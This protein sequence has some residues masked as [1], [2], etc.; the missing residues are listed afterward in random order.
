MVQLSRLRFL[1]VSLA[2]FAC[3]G[4]LLGQLSGC[5]PPEPRPEPRIDAVDPEDMPPDEPVEEPVD[6]PVGE[7]AE[8]ME[9]PAEPMEE[10]AEPMEEPAEPMEEPAEP[11]EEPAEPMEEPA[12][13]MEE[14]AEPMEEPAE[15]MEEPA[16]PAE[17]PTDEALPVDAPV[18]AYA[19]AEN[20]LA[21]VDHFMERL[22]E[23]VSTEDE[24]KDGVTRI[25]RDSNTMILIAVAL[26]LHDEDHKLKA[27]APAMLQAAQAVAATETYEA[28]KDAVAK[29][30]TAIAEGGE[31]PELKWEK[32]ASLKE[33][34]EQVPLIRASIN[35]RVRRFDR[36]TDAIAGDAVAVAVIGQ[37]SIA[38]ID[39]TI[40]P[41]KPDE[42]KKYNLDM[43]NA[44]AELLAA[45]RAA[46]EEAA[47]AAFAKLDQSC[48]DCHVIFHPEEVN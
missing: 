17:E 24:Y 12:E 8:P 36:N 27:N 40:E 9:E 25:A 13:P 21:Q 14:P 39:E 22:E 37:G 33:L 6:E 45:A 30:K 16:E 48:N 35:R 26:G 47:Q 1:F 28:A 10:P 5:A 3:A 19:P 44:A 7:P 2:V 38:N 11:M 20:L 32:V 34:M 31:G 43:R 15:P 41:E 29:L 18:S 4:L 46:D 42:W 23:A